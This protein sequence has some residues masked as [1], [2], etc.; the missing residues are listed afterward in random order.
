MGTP[1]PVHPPKPARAIEP[2]TPVALQLGLFH[3]GTASFDPDFA[4]VRRV[5]LDA[6]AWVDHLPG[7]VAG[8]D[9]LFRE[10]LRTRAW[11]QRWREMRG[12]RVLEPRLT[13]PWS[14]DSGEP[15]VPALIDDMRRAL[16]ERYG[17]AFDS[18]G[19][20]LYRYGRDSVAWHS[21]RIDPRIAEPF[22]AL[23]SLGDAR[24]FLLRPRGGGRSTGFALGHGDLLVTGGR[25]QRTWEHSVP[26]VARAGP[27]ISLAFRHGLDPRGYG[28]LSPPGPS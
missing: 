23:V 16:G 15:L 3:A 7:W 25:T 10:V 12:A 21:D 17:A 22:V 24:R 2:G 1:P 4:G 27:R 11:A 26:K 19:F 8:A 9:A 14:L 6:S 13:A 5:W 28:E 20:N 18:V